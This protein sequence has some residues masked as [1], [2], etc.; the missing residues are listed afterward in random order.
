[1]APGGSRHLA[2]LLCEQRGKW[3]ANVDKGWHKPETGAPS[4]RE[5]RRVKIAMC[6][7]ADEKKKYLVQSARWAQ[8]IRWAGVD[9]D[10][11]V[12]F[13][14]GCPEPYRSHFERLGVNLATLPRASAWHGPSNKLG[15]LRVPALRDYD[16]VVL[17]DCDIVVGGEIG[18]EMHPG[19]IRAKPADLATLSDAVLEQLFAAA[20]QPIPARQVLT[21]IDRV[22]KHPY[23][24]S[25][26]IVFPGPML[27]GFMDRWL[28]WNGFVLANS[29][30]LG[31]STFFTD[32]ASFALALAE[33][34]DVYEELPVGMNFPCHL[35]PHQYPEDLREVEPIV[36]HYHDRVD[37]DTG[38]LLPTT[39]PGPDRVIARYNARVA[40]AATRDAREPQPQQ[41]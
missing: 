9:A 16:F 40:S 5:K 7:A 28:H 14:D 15:V 22:P 12:G 13:T 27:S 29:A 38:F 19:R 31:D 37:D 10:L 21:S 30:L 34:V 17:S 18:A 26:F 4:G 25:G 1:V 2:P 41:Q 32:Q 24:N 20:G 11:F 8:A 3:T 33:Y 23:C 6:C 39:L 35:Q 36:L